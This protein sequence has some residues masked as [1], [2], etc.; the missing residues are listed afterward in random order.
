MNEQRLIFTDS[1]KK[2]LSL[3]ADGKFHS[4]T[5]LA[6]TLNI[7]R[8]AIWKQIESLS[9]EY[10][11]EIIAVS[12]KGY[13]LNRPLELLSETQI[14]SGLSQQSAELLSNLEIYQQIDSTNRYLVERAQTATASGLVCFAESQTAGKGRRGRQWVSPF[15]SNIYLSILWRFQND[16]ASISGL[17]LAVGVAVIRALRELGLTDI[18]LK[19]PNDIY[20]QQ[21][22]LGGILIEV[23]GEAG[24]SCSAVIGLGL[25][26][27]LPEKET[28]SIT[29]PWVDLEQIRTASP[30]KDSQSCSRN[31]IS[32]LLL[33]HLLPVI[34]HFETDTLQQY[35]S[36][37]RSY[38]VMLEKEVSI[39]IGNQAIDGIV[40]GINDDGMLLLQNNAG[41]LKTYAS[42]EVSFRASL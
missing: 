36:E 37:W 30:L 1:Q 38:D 29:Q 28:A 24:G 11:V 21:K 14:K 16:P 13:K 4:G 40:K 23:S 19:W 7:S 32:S 17:S 26:L 8:S 10:G 35:L 18:G 20:W 27:Y 39:Y 3:L 31:Y 15:G 12:G 41:E 9:S 22:K 33:N 34:A 5:V 42:G 25:N 2:L 6:N